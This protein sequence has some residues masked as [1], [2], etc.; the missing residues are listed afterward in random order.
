MFVTQFGW[1]RI[2]EIH[3]NSSEKVVTVSFFLRL[4]IKVAIISLLPDNKHLPSR[5]IS[6]T[7]V[8]KNRI[9][10]SWKHASKCKCK[11]LMWH[12]VMQQYGVT[13][14]HVPSACSACLWYLQLCGATSAPSRMTWCLLSLWS[15]VYVC[16]VN[17][18]LSYR[19]SR[20]LSPV[21][22]EVSLMI[23]GSGFLLQ[24][25]S[26]AQLRQTP[27]EWKAWVQRQVW[28]IKLL[29]IMLLAIHCYSIF[30]V[31]LL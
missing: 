26:H 16:G 28:G 6:W 17:F 20:N 27:T 3:Y 19:V 10:Q 14:V 25:L 8:N 4:V 5:S 12:A 7:L 22:P 2:C 1:A 24:I 18:W 23:W 11:T 21:V 9:Q 31:M 15:A 29:T 30:L 13:K